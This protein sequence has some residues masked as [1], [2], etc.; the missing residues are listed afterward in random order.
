M[1]RSKPIRVHT[2]WLIDEVEYFRY[3]PD[4]ANIL[5]HVVKNRHLRKRP[6]I[7]TTIRSVGRGITR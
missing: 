2:S 7:F 3:G 6:M 5:F 1:S 4:A